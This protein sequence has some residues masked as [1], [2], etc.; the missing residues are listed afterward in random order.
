MSLSVQQR[1]R[2]QELVREAMEITGGCL[3]AAGRPKTFAEMEDECIELSDL[4]SANLLQAR[5]G[6]RDVDAPSDACPTC[7][8]RGDRLDDEPQVLQTDRGEVGWNEPAYH[9]RYCRRDFFSLG[10]P[11]WGWTWTRRSARGYWPRRCMRGPRPR[12]F[13][14]PARHWRKLADL[15]ISDERV[16]RACLRIGE[17]RIAHHDQMQRAFEHKPLPEQIGSKPAGG[18]SPTDRLRDVRRGTSSTASA[19]RAAEAASLGRQGQTLAR[20]SDRPAAFDARHTASERSATD[21][22]TAVAL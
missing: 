18:A 22:A 3:D 16:R 10:L 8:R 20:E 11:N 9:C 14:G 1:E 2:L 6:G 19:R 7:G 5:V 4:L 13:R 17:Q 12:A 15:S 21:T